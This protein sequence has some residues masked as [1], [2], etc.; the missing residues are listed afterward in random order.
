M[1]E[2]E[3]NSARLQLA[4]ILLSGVN[5]GGCC[6]KCGWSS[7][8]AFAYVQLL[9]SL[10]PV[11]LACLSDA[12]DQAGGMPEPVPLE[13][14]AVCKFGYKHTVPQYGS[15]RRGKLENLKNSNGLC[16]LCVLSGGAE[17][18]NYGISPEH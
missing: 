6:H 7:K 4:Q 3:R 16:L 1:L 18:G 11:G 8:Y 17:S 13:E 12:L 10:W 5:T 2:E 14:S 15:D 9:E